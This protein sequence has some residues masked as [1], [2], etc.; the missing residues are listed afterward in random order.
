MTFTESVRT[1][2]AKYA[3]FDGRAARSEYW[4]F[5]LFVLLASIPLAFID[6]MIVAPGLGYESFKESTPQFVSWLFS[7]AMFLPSI[8][9]AVRRMHDLGKSGWWVLIVLIPILGVL[10][11]IY[12]FVQ[13]GTEGANDY[14]PDPLAGIAH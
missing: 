5:A 1:V 7:L 2:L 6:Q 14:G 8:A 10:I 12:W 9:V 11:M 3:T 4:W 13:R